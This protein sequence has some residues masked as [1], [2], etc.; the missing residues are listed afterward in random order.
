MRLV[1][2][3]YGNGV[4][5]Y[6]KEGTSETA[7]V[8]NTSIKDIISKMNAKGADI[9][10]I[11]MQDKDVQNLIVL[12]NNE[13]LAQKMDIKFNAENKNLNLFSNNVD[14]NKLADLIDERYFENTRLISVE[15][16]NFFSFHC[17]GRA[18]EKV[19]EFIEVF[20]EE[21]ALEL[22]RKNKSIKY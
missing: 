22:Q 9:A 2:N 12:S 6:A 5:V 21:Q 10:C 1:Q 4:E 13:L 3:F 19:V 16:N 20:V 7:E 11:T 15:D 8:L 18:S 14:A 17:T